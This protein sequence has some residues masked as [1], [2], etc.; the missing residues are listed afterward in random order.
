MLE[1]NSLIQVRLWPLWYQ[2]IGMSWEVPGLWEVA[3]CNVYKSSSEAGPFERINETP[4]QTMF[5]SD[6]QTQAFSI[7][8]KDFYQIEVVLTNGGI[9]RSRSYTWDNI[10]SS[11]VELRAKEITRREKLLLKKFTGVKSI[12]LSRKTYG[13]RCP[14]CWDVNLEKTL[15]S[16]CPYCYGVG[17]E[18]GYVEG[19][20]VLLQYDP[21]PDNITKDP[22]IGNIESNVISAWTTP[23]PTIT[24]RDLIIRLA[25][26]SVFN[27][28]AV[29]ETALQSVRVRQIL[30][31]EEVPKESIETRLIEKYLDGTGQ[32]KYREGSRHSGYTL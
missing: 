19:K 17:Y 2:E 9:I 21:N 4:I 6:V 8:R 7:F 22:I 18:G 27:V 16:N 13:R 1:D 3:Y 25:D 29:S 5:W 26:Y 28:E 15:D 11:W 12:W 32:F 14:H 31:L 30:Q 24:S 10:R 23:Y 20:E